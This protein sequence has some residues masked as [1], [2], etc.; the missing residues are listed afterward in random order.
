MKKSYFLAPLALGAMFAASQTAL[1]ANLDLFGTPQGPVVS[2][3]VGTPVSSTA[4]S[5]TISALLQGGG[6]VDRVTAEVLTSRFK[7]SVGDGSFGQCT[8][9]WGP[10]AAGFPS[11]PGGLTSFVV[12][13]LTWDHVVNTT[14]ALSLNDGTNTGTATVAN[15]G[16]GPVTFLMSN[17]AFAGVNL[18]NLSS[19][20]L[21]IRDSADEGRPLDASIDSVTYNEAAP[22][23]PPPVS[24]IPV[25]PP[26]GLALAAFGLAGIGAYRA[27][28]KNKK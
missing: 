9:G 19:I 3:V 20:S 10:A 6:S 4:A 13:V 17:P 15:P 23:L 8:A 16:T 11:S 14:L 5:R 25:L 27:K 24:D 12:N 2:T 1:A 22:V 7:C 26:L 28:R 21:L 18:A